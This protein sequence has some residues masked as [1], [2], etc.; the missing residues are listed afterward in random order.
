MR[1]VAFGETMI[2]LSTEENERIE[3]A[4]KLE[5]SLAG[6][7]SNFA[8]AF[9][10]LGGASSFASVFPDNPLGLWS[11]NEI[12]KHGVDVSDAL[13]TEGRMGLYFV[14]QGKKPRATE[15]IYDRKSSAFA[16]AKEFRISIEACDLVHTTGITLALSES[17]REESYRLFRKAGERGIKR[18]FDVN[19]RE[20]LWRAEEAFKAIE[21]MLD[22]VDILFSTIDDVK[23][24]F[25]LD[26]KGCAEELYA[27]YGI[28]EIV[29]TLGEDGA[30]CLKD[31]EL[32][33]EGGYEIETVDRI[34]AGDAFDA[35]F[36]LISLE[37]K[38]AGR[39]L[40]YAVASAA[41][42]HTIKGDIFYAS[43]EEVE[44]VLG[45][46]KRTFR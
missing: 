26:K 25:G 3:Q 23:R 2:R 11:L 32:F 7:E 37:E 16:L 38:D 34:G 20:K 35:V 42:A 39:A 43:R 18:S 5:L 1:A 40:R 24:V 17:A 8:I 31:G 30:L 44:E 46:R 36:A 15:V 28:P 21:P 33:K 27:R 13:L 4:K 14:E 12:R 41:L 10:R 9:A 6:A 22:S 19:Y 45:L 29:I